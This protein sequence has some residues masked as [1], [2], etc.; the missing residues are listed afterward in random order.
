[1]VRKARY[2]KQIALGLF[3]RTTA[4][5]P[6]N[7]QGANWTTLSASRQEFQSHLMQ[8]HAAQVDR[9]DQTVGALVDALNRTGQF[10]NTGLLF[11]S[12]NGASNEPGPSEDDHVYV[13]RDGRAVQYCEGGPT[14]DCP[15]SQPGPETTFA[16]IG[17]AWA[18]VANTPFRYWKV[19]G[20]RGGT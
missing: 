2:E 14:S 5:L 17:Q 13:T 11:L 10:D 18:N 1:P 19:E 3:D 7:Q 20:F 8:A 6:T 16:A 4:P 12:D 9:M 15:Y